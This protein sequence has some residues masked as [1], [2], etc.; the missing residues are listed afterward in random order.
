MT[1]KT[2]EFDFGEDELLRAREGA[3]LL[4]LS[5]QRFYAL[6]RKLAIKLPNRRLLWYRRDLVQLVGEVR[7]RGR[8][9]A[10]LKAVIP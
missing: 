9:P 4:K 10:H 2:A 3:A 5:R 7:R 8:K 6:Y 1:R